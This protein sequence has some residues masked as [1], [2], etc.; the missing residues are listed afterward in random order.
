MIL[1]Q[2]QL[3]PMFPPE[4][5]SPQPASVNVLDDLV[6]PVILP[7]WLFPSISLALST[8]LCWPAPLVPHSSLTPPSPLISYSSPALPWALS[9]P[10]MLCE[11]N[12]LVSTSACLL[13]TPSALSWCAI[14]QAPTGSL[15]HLAPP[16]S[17]IILFS[18]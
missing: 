5:S 9:P 8:S 6:L 16:W 11:A 15:V 3:P 4:L 17:F 13:C 10:A 18:L 14:T 7:T 1:L 12:P 2:S